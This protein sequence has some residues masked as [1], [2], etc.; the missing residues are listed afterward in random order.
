[1]NPEELM[2]MYSSL[3]EENAE[4]RARLKLQDTTKSFYR[5]ILTT[6]L[7]SIKEACQLAEDAIKGV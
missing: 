1:M 7:A 5:D 4:L 2:Q 6:L 3:R